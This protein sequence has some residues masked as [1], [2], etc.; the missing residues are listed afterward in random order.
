[1]SSFPSV[2]GVLGVALAWPC[3]AGPAWVLENQH[4]GPSLL[5]T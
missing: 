4:S 2:E 1:M 5:S 3:S